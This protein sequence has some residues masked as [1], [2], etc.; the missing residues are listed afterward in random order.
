[1]DTMLSREI[2][3]FNKHIKDWLKSQ[4]GK[5]VV[6]KEEQVVGFYSTFDEA[7]SVAARKFGLDSCLIRRIATEQ[8]EARIPA[9]TAGVL[10]ADPTYGIDG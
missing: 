9:M 7:L 6:I 10:H 4:E 2:A 8:E 3:Y 5:V 1:M